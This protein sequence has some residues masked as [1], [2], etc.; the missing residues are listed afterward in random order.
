MATLNASPSFNSLPCRSLSAPLTFSLTTAFF[1]RYHESAFPPVTFWLFLP[2]GEKCPIPLVLQFTIQLPHL[3]IK[4]N[5]DCPQPVFPPLTYRPCSLG[6]ECPYLHLCL[7]TFSSFKAYFPENF[8]RCLLELNYLKVG[9]L[10]KLVLLLYTVLCSACQSPL[11]GSPT[12][13]WAILTLLPVVP[14]ALGIQES[15]C[16]W[17]RILWAADG[18]QVISQPSVELWEKSSAWGVGVN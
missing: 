1:T 15:G 18:Q 9:L 12:K 4:V 5:C 11:Q 8:P 3:S 7:S 2:Q 14:S 13:M 16:L 17:E 6:L 10:Q